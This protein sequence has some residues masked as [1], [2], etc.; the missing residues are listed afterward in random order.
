MNGLAMSIVKPCLLQEMGGQRRSE[1]PLMTWLMAS[2]VE[3]V[4]HGVAERHLIYQRHWQSNGK[5][6]LM[7]CL[8]GVRTTVYGKVGCIH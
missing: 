7:Q 3:T 1:K 8:S 2:C 5:L 4:E 6:S